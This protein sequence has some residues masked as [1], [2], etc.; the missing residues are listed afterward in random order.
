[1]LF[2]DCLWFRPCITISFNVSFMLVIELAICLSIQLSQLFSYLCCVSDITR[3]CVRCSFLI[4]VILLVWF[5]V[6]Y[7]CPFMLVFSVLLYYCIYHLDV[8]CCMFLPPYYHDCASG[9]VGARNTH[10]ECGIQ[11]MRTGRSKWRHTYMP[12]IVMCIYIYICICIIVYIYIY[13]YECVYIYIY[14]YIYTYQQH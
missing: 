6:L 9:V 5:M 7:M 10:V 3:F 1:M 11:S 2:V 13:I 4:Y 12:Y 14:I 8:I